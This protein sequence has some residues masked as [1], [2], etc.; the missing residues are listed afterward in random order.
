M[1]LISTKRGK[2]MPRLGDRV[3]ERI[4]RRVL[5]PIERRTPGL[6]PVVG[7]A[8]SCG[9]CWQARKEPPAPVV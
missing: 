4:E 7:R 2:G 9:S 6:K 1:P 8:V 5:A 3:A